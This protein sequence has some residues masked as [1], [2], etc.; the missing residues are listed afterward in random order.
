ME[1][2]NYSAYDLVCSLVLEDKDID[3]ISKE[4]NLE[5]SFVITLLK[6][7]RNDYILSCDLKLYMVVGKIDKLLKRK[8]KRRIINNFGGRKDIIFNLICDG[9]SCIEICNLL[10]ISVEAYINF[11][12]FIM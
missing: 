11:L 1:K 4:L 3:E 2:I 12:K 8:K 7:A 9:K 6:K 10:G 5:K